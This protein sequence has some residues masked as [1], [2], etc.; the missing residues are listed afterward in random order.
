MERDNS[1]WRE[2]VSNVLEGGMAVDVVLGIAG[3]VLGRPDILFGAMVTGVG[4][5]VVNEAYFEDK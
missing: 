3:I 1:S 2:A 4:G 5:Y